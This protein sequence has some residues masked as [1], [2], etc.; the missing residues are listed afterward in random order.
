MSFGNHA[1]IVI[2]DFV[3]L[4]FSHGETRKLSYA[5]SHFLTP[6]Y[7]WIH[8]PQSRSRPIVCHCFA[9]G[10]GGLPRSSHFG[11]SG[12]GFYSAGGLLAADVYGDLVACWAESG[13]RLR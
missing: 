9:G 2:T 7:E 1:S 5:F 10:M 6:C 12:R 11:L 3:R 8:W 13:M 4:S